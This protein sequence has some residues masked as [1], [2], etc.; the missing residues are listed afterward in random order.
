VV[1]LAE[2]LNAWEPT[3]PCRLPEITIHGWTRPAGF[4][5]DHS[6]RIETEPSWSPDHT[7]GNVT[8]A[9]CEPQ[10]VGAPW[11][12]RKPGPGHRAGPLDP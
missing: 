9:D 5:R 2:I 8:I 3:S 4:S 11:T 10:H 7:R 6:D 1:A 12:L